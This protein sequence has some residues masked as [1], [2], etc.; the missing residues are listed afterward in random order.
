MPWSILWRTVLTI[1]LVW[2]VV[3]DLKAGCVPHQL[4]WPLL[5]AIIVL[6]AWLGSWILP[7]AFV[8]LILVELLPAV[9]RIPSV[10]VLV[11][12]LRQ[13]ALGLD[14][15]ISQFVILWWGVVYGLW[16]LNVLGGADVRIFMTLV[17]AFPQQKMVAALWG[18]LLVAGIL[19]LVI[20]YR[21]HSLIPLLRAA[22]G[23]SSGRYPTREEL[24]EQG[25]PTTP[26][27]ALGA[28]V[29]LWFLEA[30]DGIVA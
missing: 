24:K 9:W 10:V 7:V 13:V 17:A 2:I 11:V 21:H 30:I 27:L 16:M 28:F 1:W 22:R 29:Y 6:R 25:R 23:L 15:P 5:I 18:G 14:D 8:G 20:V 3:C 26:G 19:W 4:S 12:G